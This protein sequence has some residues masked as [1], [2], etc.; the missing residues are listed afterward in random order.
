MSAGQF[1]GLRDLSEN[2][3]EKQRSLERLDLEIAGLDPPKPS[4]GQ[5]NP[6]TD[7]EL[8]VGQNLLT[9]FDD[10]R[11]YEGTVIR[12]CISHRSTVE[13]VTQMSKL[14]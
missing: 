9:R 6:Q 13:H 5:P 7:I 1:G 4:S 10:G 12:E 3:A 2:A 14:C 8:A 11:D